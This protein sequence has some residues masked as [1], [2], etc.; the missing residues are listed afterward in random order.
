MVDTHIFFF[1]IISID[2]LFSFFSC[3]MSKRA[4]KN[5]NRNF[6]PIGANFLLNVRYHSVH[7]EY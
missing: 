1:L 4:I 2:L 3:M 7:R 6:V 5:M